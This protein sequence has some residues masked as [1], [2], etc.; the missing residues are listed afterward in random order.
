MSDTSTLGGKQDSSGNVRRCRWGIEKEV[1]IP[2]NGQKC[3]WL[4]IGRSS[5]Y[6]LIDSMVLIQLQVKGIHPKATVFG[7]SVCDAKFGC[8]CGWKIYLDEWR[9]KNC[10][11]DKSPDGRAPRPFESAGI[12]GKVKAQSAKKDSGGIGKGLAAAAAA[13]SLEQSKQCE[14]APP[15]N[16]G[17]KCGSHAEEEAGPCAPLSASQPHFSAPGGRDGGAQPGTTGNQQEHPG[18]RSDV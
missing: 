7:P 8:T 10:P 9:L 2:G 16:I 4:L 17:V 18:K 5:Y 12:P 14:A 11:A 15:S 6:R 13:I 3:P 1:R